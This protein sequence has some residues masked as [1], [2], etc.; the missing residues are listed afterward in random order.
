MG[1]GGGGVNNTTLTRR[2][3]I[4]RHRP[5]FPAGQWL[6][7]TL[8]G[9]ASLHPPPPPHLSSAPSGI[10]TNGDVKTS[11]RIPTNNNNNNNNNKKNNNK[12]TK[13]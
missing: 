11:K 9:R 2:N 6:L 7:M 10:R 3:S 8:I 1:V 4:S 5:P 12:N 13:D